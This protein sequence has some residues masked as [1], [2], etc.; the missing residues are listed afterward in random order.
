MSEK[1]VIEVKP[2]NEKPG[3]YSFFYD[4]LKEIARSHGYNL[5][6]HGSM[7]RDLD[8]IALPWSKPLSDPEIMISEMASYLGGEVLNQT[9]KQLN[10]FP[11]GRIG[12]VIELARQILWTGER[13]TDKQYY[14]DISVMPDMEHNSGTRPDEVE[15]VLDELEQKMENLLSNIVNMHPA[16]LWREIK[17]YL[18]EIRKR[19]EAGK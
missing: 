14:L 7:N 1:E 10:C 11:H 15:E 17:Y 18:E 8:L 2:L 6:V 4:R 13:V 3:L 9:T 12:Y 16:W 5:V 19:R